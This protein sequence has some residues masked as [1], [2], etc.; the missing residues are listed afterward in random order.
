MVSSRIYFEIDYELKKK[1]M[2]LLPVNET[3]VKKVL[4]NAIEDYVNKNGQVD[5]V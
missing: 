1:F 3:T 2:G 4:T 5:W